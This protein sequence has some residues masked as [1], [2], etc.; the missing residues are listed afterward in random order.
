[1]DLSPFT[2]EFL[3]EYDVRAQIDTGGMATVYRAYQVDL[4]RDCALKL[5]QPSAFDEEDALQRFLHEGRITARLN[6]P[7]IVRVYSIGT[8]G[9]TPYIALELVEGSNLKALVQKHPGG[10]PAPKALPLV[11]QIADALSCAHA[12][13]IVHRDLKPENVLLTKDGQAKVADFGLAK[14]DSGNSVR[15]RTGIILGTPYYM[16]P[17]QINSEKLTAATDQYA[18]GIMLFELLSGKPP[19]LGENDLSILLK[20]TKEAPPSLSESLSSVPL[21]LDAVV[22]QM[23]AK[24][25]SKRLPDMAAV[26][27]R[28]AA[29]LRDF[30]A[31]ARRSVARKRVS[32]SRGAL[33]EFDRSRS[34]T[35]GMAG[36]DTSLGEDPS[37]AGLPALPSSRE[38]NR[39]VPAVILST[40][41]ILAIAGGLRWWAGQRGDDARYRQGLEMI[42]GR[43]GVL[44]RWKSQIPYLSQAELSWQDGQ[45]RRV[46]RHADPSGE[47]KRD[48]SLRLGNLRQ[49]LD[50]E[51]R[52]RYPNGENS[53]PIPLTL[54]GALSANFEVVFTDLNR[55]EL[56]LRF[57][58]PVYLQAIELHRGETVPGPDP[59]RLARKHSLSL[60]LVPT[61]RWASIR[62]QLKDALDASFHE[63]LPV[64]VL[65]SQ[66]LGERLLESLRKLREG[67]TNSRLEGCKRA[68]IA[69]E[70]GIFRKEEPRRRELTAN[71]EAEATSLSQQKEG[72]RRRA[73]RMVNREHLPLFEGC[74]A[75]LEVADALR[76]FRKRSAA[77]FRSSDVPLPQRLEVYEAL[78]DLAMV[79]RL[80]HLFTGVEALEIRKLY[81][82][83]V[84][85]ECIPHEGYR[86]QESKLIA[87]SGSTDRP[88]ALRIFA[89]PDGKAFSGLRVGSET[90]NKALDLVNLFKDNSKDSPIHLFGEVDASTFVPMLEARFQVPARFQTVKR[91]FW[92]FYYGNFNLPTDLVAELHVRSRKS[93]KSFRIH[94]WNDWKTYQGVQSTFEEVGF[95][96]H[97]AC[98]TLPSALLSDSEYDCRLHLVPVCPN[99][100]A[101]SHFTALYLEAQ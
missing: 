51:V 20:H 36:L 65:G 92:K 89:A 56:E 45:R 43:G 7:H 84:R 50:Y 74:V 57:S 15:T 101:V 90:V 64:E 1:M 22:Q 59:E 38:K 96:A 83:F 40:L 5:F 25:P 34:P 86:S 63:D 42:P 66:R 80:I 14:V 82:S 87:L 23:L 100:T 53:A 95:R 18:L 2:P 26:R 46:L 85:D 33:S 8:V 70:E 4:D 79:D 11:L 49:D 37:V 88:W 58:E 29:V 91:K 10:M 30:P 27:D 78:L 52:L 72:T 61:D 41:L 69:L 39:L 19:F 76:R 71:I 75:K 32:R 73:R 13:G 21:E 93:Q 68:L 48:H 98:T 94:F 60:S 77:W 6:H 47:A 67:G 28:L 54:P 97:W 44:L 35:M 3:R 17:E 16:A 9:E 31:L 62:L 99:R 55:V 81:E 12:H 24:K